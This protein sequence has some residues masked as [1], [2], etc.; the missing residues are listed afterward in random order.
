MAGA[1]EEEQHDVERAPDSLYPR[2]ALPMSRPHR[3]SLAR[4]RACLAGLAGL[5]SAGCARALE[6]RWIPLARGFV[7][8]SGAGLARAWSSGPIAVRPEDGA[9]WLAVELPA[10]AWRAHESA[11]E[12]LREWQAP[13]PLPRAFQDRGAEG[14]ALE[15]DG[16]AVASAPDRAR[17]GS[18]APAGRPL[19]EAH[20]VLLRP[21]A[22]PPGPGRFSCRVTR[23]REEDGVWRAAVQELVADGLSLWPGER[24]ETAVE[25]PPGSALR[26][27]TVARSLGRPGR[28][29][30]RVTRDGR[31]LLAHEEAIASSGSGTW[32]ELALDA[33]PARLAFEVTGDPAA[34][35]FLDPGIGPESVG[36]P[37]GARGRRPS[38]T[39]CSSWPTPSG[40]TSSRRGAVRR[41]SRPS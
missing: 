34:S 8:P 1:L 29:V 27:T 12:S 23:G 25:V 33:G 36:A 18:R 7:P 24:F 38:P 30:F 5:F 6:T 16:S 10:S 13:R 22:E 4:A 19:G 35:A 9:L 40:R 14:L 31:E 15:L 37:G 2:A 39:S 11:G 3:E 41:R 20:L 17:A 26:F 32:H 21:S 28:V